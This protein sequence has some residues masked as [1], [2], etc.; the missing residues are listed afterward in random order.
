M[1][2]VFARKG[3]HGGEVPSV[4]SDS[5]HDETWRSATPDPIGKVETVEGSV[6]VIRGSTTIVPNVGDALFRNDVIETGVDGFAAIVFADGTAFHLKASTRLALDEFI[7]DAAKSPSS[8]VFRVVRGVFGFIAGKLA[9]TG[10]LIIETPYG[11]IQSTAQVAGFGSLTFSIFT[12]SLIH[13]LKAASADVAL[14]DYGTID[15]RDLKHGVFE[16]ITK[17]AHPRRIIVD[18][19]GQTIVL[20]RGAAGAIN[21]EQVAN[22]PVQM[23]QYQNAYQGVH[24]TYL[25]GQQDPFIQHFQQEQ[26]ANNALPTNNLGNAANNTASPASVGGNDSSTPPTVLASTEAAP[27]IPP[28]QTTIPP[29]TTTAPVIAPVVEVTNT[30]VVAPVQQQVVIPSPPVATSTTVVQT[31]GVN[32][33][34]SIT[35]VSVTESGSTTGSDAFTVTLSDSNGQLSA[36]SLASG[37]GG[38]VTGPG[39]TLTISGTLTQVNADLATLQ[40]TDPTPGPDTITV[41]VTNSLGN[42]ATAQ[43]IAVLANGPPVIVVPTTPQAA[44]VNQAA[45]ISGV[46]ITESGN[47]TGETFTVTLSDSTGQ[48]SANTSA[49]GGG[50]TISGSSSGSGTTLTISGSLSQVQAD[51][52]TLKDIDATAG[53]DPITVN[54]TDSFGNSAVA[55][56]IGV[57]VNGAPAVAIT[58]TGGVTNQ[59]SQLISGTVTETNETLVS[60][61]TVDLYDNGS[62]TA[63]GTATV[64]SD[65]SW[66][67]TVTLAAGANSIVAKDTDVAGNTGSSAAVSY[68]LDTTAP[69]VAI[70][71]TGGVTNQASQLISGTV[72][73]TNETLVSGTTVDLYDNGS[74]TALGTATV[75]SDGSWSTT[76]TL[77]AGANSIVAKDTDVAGNTGSSAAVSYTLDTTAPT[78]AITST[79]GVTNQASQLISGTVTET[80]ETLVSGTTVDLYDNGSGTALGTATVQADGSWSDDA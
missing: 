52:T 11:Q 45:T 37:G 65:G 20:H 1:S 12:V 68:T 67:T 6:N 13:E 71:S 51:L 70:T 18:D 60:G 63:L 9:T 59:A 33:P 40:D 5:T 32:Q 14:L 41:N 26:H 80:N 56:T 16:I 4:S 61:T 31:L 73:E 72:T 48:L 54:A 27:V 7:C 74:G 15:Y 25:Q 53:S 28:A 38:T 42:S 43:T 77:A 49:S 30:A 62:G 3:R 34:G 22:T 21:V 23:A 19:P 8:A 78:V 58:S 10:R 69:A 29:S 66:S 36:N 46:S 2:R 44:G 76:V 47:T 17:E 75:Q 79:G 35:G 64:Q 50:G 55:K 57:T 24:A 39:T